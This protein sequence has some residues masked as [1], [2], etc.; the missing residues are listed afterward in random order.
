MRNR[1]CKL[2]LSFSLA[3]FMVALNSYRQVFCLLF[4]VE[5]GELGHARS[6]T[7]PQFIPGLQ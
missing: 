7:L 4:G 3:F 5:T 2:T 6:F 1:T